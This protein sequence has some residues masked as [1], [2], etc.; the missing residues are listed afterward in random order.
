MTDTIVAFATAAGQA[1]FSVLR[2]SGPEAPQ[3]A[4]KIFRPGRKRTAERFLSAFMC[5]D[6]V[7]NMAS[8]TAK[9]GFVY[10]PQTGEALDQV[11]L[12]RFCAPKTYTGEEVVEISCHGSA[13]IRQKLLQFCL[14]A[15]ARL[16]EAGE[17]T[18][19]AFLH[20]KLD[21]NQAEAVID[22]IQ[23]ETEAQSRQALAQLEGD[24]SKQIRQLVQDLRLA[25]AQLELALQYPEHEESFLAEAQLPTLLRAQAEQFDKL[26]A[27]YRRGRLIREGLQLALLG[28]PNAG[29]ST[30]FN[31]L[32]REERAIVTPV[33]GTT[34]DVLEASLSLGGQLVHLSDTAGLRETEDVVEQI[35]VDRSRRES[36]RADWL[37]LLFPADAE[38]HWQREWEEL[39]SLSLRSDHLILP[40]LS[41]VDLL[42]E[43]GRG[44]KLEELTLALQQ[45]AAKQPWGSTVAPRFLSPLPLA[46][47]AS[48]GLAELEE[49][50]LDLL[51]QEGLKAEHQ[52]A[53]INNERQFHCLQ[54]ARAVLA[55]LLQELEFLPL[56]LLSWKLERL[57]GELSKLLGEDAG[58]ELWKTVFQRF[59]VGK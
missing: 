51:Q 34:R 30:L 12:T 37:L 27:G 16:A 18:Q 44:E 32:L 13:L 31:A 2:M 1:G 41:K 23:S 19:R 25:Q 46:V 49:R 28:R 57:L 9:L 56:D 4:D 11:V 10:E 24:L 48:Q 35:G 38:D 39:A 36:R 3:I 8:Y 33:A 47:K 7:Q 20:G 21:L 17:F 59:C 6:V 5:S 58:E 54:E 42:P 15:G 45:F 43:G 40:L 14:A 55:D 22:L 26:L 29:K 52:Q 53:L 50:L